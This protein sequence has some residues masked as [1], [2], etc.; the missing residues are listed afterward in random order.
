MNK[1]INIKLLLKRM[2]SRKKALVVEREKLYAL[3]DD[4]AEWSDNVASAWQDVQAAIEK[5]EGFKEE[6]P[7]CSDCGIRLGLGEVHECEIRS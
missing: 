5:L 3:G 2:E 4:I 7:R 6:F 1:K